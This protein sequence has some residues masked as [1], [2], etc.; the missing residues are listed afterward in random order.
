[1]WHPGKRKKSDVTS[2]ALRVS[3]DCERVLDGSYLDSLCAAGSPIP[4]WVWLNKLAHSPEPELQ[5]IARRPCVLQQRPDLHAWA[6]TLSFLAHELVQ[7]SARCGRSVSALQRAALL[8][9]E[10]ELMASIFGPSELTRRVLVALEE[11]ARHRT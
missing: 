4:S 7:S 3:A 11:T 2:D 1:M 10:L 9:L 6:R 8:P 5:L